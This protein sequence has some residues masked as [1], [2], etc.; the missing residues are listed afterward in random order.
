MRLKICIL[1]FAICLPSRTM[2]ALPLRVLLL[3]GGDGEARQGQALALRRALHETGRFQVR[4]NEEPAGLTAAT[5]SGYDAV[6]VDS[7]VRPTGQEPLRSFVESGKGIVMLRGLTCGLCG[8]ALGAERSQPAPPR[9]LSVRWTDRGHAI[10]A[11]LPETFLTVDQLWPDRATT[12]GAHLLATSLA[13]AGAGAAPI[14]WTR[15]CGKGRIFQTALGENP[16]LFEEP[17]FL[18]ALLR[19]VEWAASGVVTL[20]V[21]EAAHPA[22]A[23]PVRTVVVTGGHTHH[24][25]FY[26]LFEGSADIQATVDPHPL[27][28]RR[29][30]LR[31]R[32]DVLTLYDSMQEITEQERGILQS[33]VE[34]GKGLVVLHHALVDYCNWKWWYEEVVGG[35]WYETED[36]PPKWKTTW[37]EGVELLVYPVGRHPVTEGVGPLHI[38][39]ETYKGMWLSPDNTVLMKTDEPS[40]DGPVVWISP[41]RKSRVVVIE[42]GHDRRAHL[43]PGYR[44]LVQN[45]VRWAGGGAQ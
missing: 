17:G 26:D 12:A 3:S 29:P 1:A 14:I 38:W 35:R 8:A 27:P 18:N 33:F 39:D 32:Y 10:S 11:G 4:L 43:H 36:K 6:V 7:D 40:S 44:R 31:T 19:G 15:R 25:T 37:K 34:S 41:Y 13:E 22:P 24:A 16:A 23:R 45:A 28:Y 30:D 21:M 42:L 9:P 2:A 5:L 20:P